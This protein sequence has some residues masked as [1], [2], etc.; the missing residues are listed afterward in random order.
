MKVV[1]DLHHGQKYHCVIAAKPN[2]RI[3]QLYLPGAQVYYWQAQAAKNK[4]KGCRRRQHDSQR[5]PETVIGH[6]MRD[7]VQSKALCISHGG[8]LRNVAPQHVRSASQ[9]EQVSEHYSMRRLRSIRENFSRSQIEI[10][11]LIGQDGPSID[12]DKNNEDQQPARRTHNEEQ[13]LHVMIQILKR[14][15]ASPTACRIEEASKVSHP[16]FLEVWIQTMIITDMDIDPLKNH[17]CPINPKERQRRSM[18]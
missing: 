16:S 2:L 12:I 9:E 3:S 14:S 7:G 8:H 5:G 13:H 6:E 1:T 10:E 4:M 15:R 18:F 11:S 17:R